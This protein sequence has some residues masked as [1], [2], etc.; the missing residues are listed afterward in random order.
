ML[1]WHFWRR[2]FSSITN[3]S[4]KMFSKIWLL[5]Y[6]RNKLQDFFFLSRVLWL[7]V[8]IFLPYTYKYVWKN[9]PFSASYL[10]RISNIHIY[11]QICI[12]CKHFYSPAIFLQPQYPPNTFTVNFCVW[13]NI[14]NIKLYQ[15]NYFKCMVQ[16]R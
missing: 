1:C 13:Q 2:N 14:H 12:I 4:L 5:A 16:R 9:M 3:A 8:H 7:K 10:R 11:C 15:F 6:T